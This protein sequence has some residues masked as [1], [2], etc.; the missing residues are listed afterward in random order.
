MTCDWLIVARLNIWKDAPKVAMNTVKT[1]FHVIIP[2]CIADFLATFFTTSL[3]DFESQAMI[4][5]HILA[6]IERA[7]DIRKSLTFN[8]QSDITGKALDVYLKLQVSQKKLK[9][10]ILGHGSS[11]RE[12]QV[13]YRRVHSVKLVWPA[14]CK[15]P[16]LPL[17][18][19]SE[20]SMD[21]SCS[22]GNRRH[23]KP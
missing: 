13:A 22:P 12:L 4:S 10:A 15:L 3:P 2:R 14:F 17:P 7:R 6:K 1:K 11:N 18:A 23:S 9:V 5:V 16:L 19:S 21:F 20:L 8:H